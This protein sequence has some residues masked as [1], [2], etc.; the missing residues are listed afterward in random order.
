MLDFLFPLSPRLLVFLVFVLHVNEEQDV[1]QGGG[2]GE[3]ED[4]GCLHL[5]SR[6]RANIWTPDWPAQFSRPEDFLVS[7][8]MSVFVSILVNEGKMKKKH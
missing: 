2:G 3:D 1:L 5:E 7:L 4:P 8:G 6:Q